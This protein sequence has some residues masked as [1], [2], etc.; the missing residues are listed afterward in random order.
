MGVHSHEIHRYSH[1]RIPELVKL[2]GKDLK[3]GWGPIE[4]KFSPLW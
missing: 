1:E 3:Q 2:P 4:E